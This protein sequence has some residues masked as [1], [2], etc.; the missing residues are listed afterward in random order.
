MKRAQEQKDEFEKKVENKRR[1]KEDKREAKWK[2][3]DEER[4]DVE[5]R[6]DIPD[7]EAAGEQD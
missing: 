3:G 5:A 6:E 7:K 1:K 4:V 2:K